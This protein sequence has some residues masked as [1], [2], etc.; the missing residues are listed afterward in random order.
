VLKIL[1]AGSPDISSVVLESLIKSKEVDIVCVLTNP[2]S[3]QGRHKTLV[4]TP[5]ATVARNASIPVLEP[6]KLD[7]FVRE[8]IK[9]FSPDLL[10]CFAYGKIFGPKFM[11]L[12][13]QGGIN[14]HPSLLPKYRGCAPVPAALLAGDKKTGITIQRL[15]Q[16]MDSGDI[17]LQKELILTGKETAGSL[18]ETVAQMGGDLLLKVL[19]Q[20]DSGTE[21]PVPQNEEDASFCE[22]LK[23]EDG[24][25]DWSNTAEEI[26]CK[27]RAFNPWPGAYT[28]VN[29]TILRLHQSKVYNSDIAEAQI[30][31]EE[32]DRIPGKVIG[33]DSKEGIL[34]QTGSGIIAVQNLQWQ[35]KKAM[36][37]KDFMNGS[38]NFPGTI[39]K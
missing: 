30:V 28:I 12:F 6:E 5:V 21:T 32:K 14:L 9:N 27:I 20:I 8:Q 24:L 16:K 2:P 26:D 25:I 23:K 36:N 29:D 10:V 38:R 1:Y 18:L 19:S 7:S 15:A 3:P 39:C 13:P 4:E 22:L 34:I 37:C 17:L 33:T 35:A 11:E 31:V